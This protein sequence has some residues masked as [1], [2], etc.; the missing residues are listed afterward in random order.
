LPIICYSIKP[1]TV[2]YQLQYIV[3][4]PDASSFD[5]QDKTNMLLS[6]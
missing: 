1:I 5:F 4:L 2:Y 6:Y 3:F